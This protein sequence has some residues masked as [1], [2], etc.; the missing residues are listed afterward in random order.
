MSKSRATFPVNKNFIE[1]VT[2]PPASQWKVAA[3]DVLITGNL[4]S[5]IRRKTL[6]FTRTSAVTHRQMTVTK[7]GFMVIYDSDE[8]GY[9]INLKD[10]AKMKTSTVALMRKTA[11]DSGWNGFFTGAVFPF[12]PFLD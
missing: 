8:R 10:A 12:Y 2:L 7:Q 1:K 11:D 5:T 4:T 6:L 3:E 9:V